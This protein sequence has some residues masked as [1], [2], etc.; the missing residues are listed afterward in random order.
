[1]TDESASL[2]HAGRELVTNVPLWDAL[3]ANLH[4]FDLNVIRPE[5][6]VRWV[7]LGVGAIDLTPYLA[8]RTP[9]TR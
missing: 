9:D 8:D 2:L 5:F 4:D 3:G 7:G 6:D 1:M